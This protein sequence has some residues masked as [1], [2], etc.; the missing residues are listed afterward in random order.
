MNVVKS[1]KD[2]HNINKCILKLKHQSKSKL[3]NSKGHAIL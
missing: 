1:I 2:T 3:S